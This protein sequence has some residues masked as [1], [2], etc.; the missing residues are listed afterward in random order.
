MHS[1]YRSAPWTNLRISDLGRGDD[2]LRGRLVDAAGAL[3]RHAHDRPVRD[4]PAQMDGDRL[5]ALEEPCGLRLPA[6]DHPGFVGLAGR[7]RRE[8]GDDERALALRADDDRAG[9]APK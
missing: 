9:G 6:P 1:L 8:T 2:R 5:A 4:R 7:S 3:D